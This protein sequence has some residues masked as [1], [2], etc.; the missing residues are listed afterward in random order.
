MVKPIVFMFSGQ[1]SQYHQ[2]GRELFENHPGFGRWMGILDEIARQR[3]G[4]SMMDELYGE[5]KPISVEFDHP[6]YTHPAIFMVE[7]ALARILL[8]AGIE[9]DY[10]LGASLGEFTAASIT[11]VF[12]YEE[13]IPALIEQAEL[14]KAQCIKGGMTAIVQD[15]GLYNEQTVLFENSELAARNYS[16]HFVVSGG[17]TSL[18]NIEGF[19]KEEGITYQPLPVSHGFHSALMEPV[20]SDLL[21]LLEPLNHHAPDIPFISCVKSRVMDT[22]PKNYWWDVVRKPVEF[23]GAIEW[24]EKEQSYIYIDLGPS[25]TL[26]NFVK[27]NLTNGS[28]SEIY[29]ILSPFGQG[30]KH[31]KKVLNHLSEAEGPGRSQK[32]KQKASHTGKDKKM[33]AW[34]FPGQGSQQ[35]GMGGPLFD[36]F[37]ELTAKAD[38]ILGYSIKDLCLEDAQNRLVQTEYTQPALF[39]VN[40]LSYYRK[41]QETEKKPDFVAGHSLGEY[42]ALLAAGGIDFETGLKL[43]KKRGELMSRATGGSMAAIVNC[44]EADIVEILRENG[45]TGIDIANYNAPSQIVVSGVADQ[46]KQSVD[47]FKAAGITAIQLNVSGA[48]HSRLMQSSREEFEAFLKDFD[49]SELHIPAISNVHARPYESTDIAANLADQITH[50]VKWTESIRYLMGQGDMEFEEIGPGNVL[51]NLIAK[52]KKEAD[53]LIIDEAAESTHSVEA[54][55][56]AEN[57]G[58]S[59]GITPESLGSEA[60]RKTFGLKYAY[61]TGAMVRGIASKELVVRMGKA[62]LMGYLGTGGM[63]ISQIENDIQFIQAE[64]KNGQAYGMNLLSDISNPKNEDRIVD[65]Y[66][67]HGI[68]NVEAAA[69]MQITPSLV[70]YRLNGLSRDRDGTVHVGHRIMAKVSRPEVAES[71]LSPAP[72]A[73]VQKLLESGSISEEQVRLSKEIPMADDLCVEADSGGHTDQGNMSVLLPTM[74]RLRDEIANKYD[75][76]YKVQVGAAGGIGTP[77]AAAS[78]FVL[79]ADFILTGS[80]NQCTVEAGTSD[81]VKDMLQQINVQDTDYAPAG[82][83]FEFGAKVQVV[84]KGV[85]FPARANKLYDLYRH[86][87]A[88]DDIDDKTKRQIQDRYFKRSFD[89]IYEDTKQFF[90]SHLPEEIERAERNP[91]HKMALVFRWYLFHTMQLALQGAVDHK[92]DFQIHCGPALGAFNQWVKGTSHEDWRNRHVDEIA[93][94]LMQD[95]AVLLNRRYQDLLG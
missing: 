24:L 57:D 64:L 31:L 49:F 28:D 29:P 7:Y 52:I 85:F 61:V 69:Y 74:I 53:P 32:R 66:L 4:I 19:L 6:I 18:K 1:G 58:K 51:T 10:V 27:Y 35:K 33:I 23:Q 59:K 46:V 36:E 91:K 92:V 12:G 60:F 94:K 13:L 95:T 75:Y 11:N 80:V 70:R 17:T 63:D 44:S 76:S 88:W 8:E 47:V 5:D 72:D 67:K 82:D 30:M 87:N 83:M 81:A 90:S 2:M 21:N 86:Y 84:R 50:S 48:F 79:G 9:P 25:G 20:Q 77:E 34:V 43:V 42:N 55:A 16:S 62:G 93:E 40:A 73:V 78:A 41:I 22:I 37:P 54:A 38:E 39:V 89:D 56:H 45:F 65:L 15:H 26:A 3:L 14:I 68:K 71:F